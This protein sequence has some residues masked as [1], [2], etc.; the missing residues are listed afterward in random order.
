M[1]YLYKNLVN[2]FFKLIYGKITKL[3][4]IKNSNELKIYC[5]KSNQYKLK[6]YSIKNGRVFTDCNTNVAYITNNKI[7]KSISY[8]QNKHKIANIDY[9]STLL[10]GT[11]K[12]KNKYPSRS[13]TTL[14]LYL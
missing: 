1:I 12:F 2:F 11:N 14:S 6:L 13:A 7:I 3:K 9:N 8:Q 10:K 4:N 5:L